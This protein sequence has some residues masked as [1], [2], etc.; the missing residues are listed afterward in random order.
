M[1]LHTLV[2][3]AECTAARIARL[4]QAF[5]HDFELP[6][7]SVGPQKAKRVSVIQRVD[8][9]VHIGLHSETLSPEVEDLMSRSEL[10]TRRAMLGVEAALQSRGVCNS[11]ARVVAEMRSELS[12]F[13]IHSSMD[14]RGVYQAK[15]EQMTKVVIS[16]VGGE[17][18]CSMRSLY[19]VK[20][21]Y[22]LV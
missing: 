12:V 22:C 16:L 6:E 4:M 8:E 11:S 20:I 13:V 1:T 2:L 21:E 19:G 3:A 18:E 15:Q 17:Q 5:A 7:E 10:Q 14:K 9:D